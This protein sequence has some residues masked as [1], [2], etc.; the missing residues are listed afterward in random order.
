MTTQQS[1]SVSLF[2]RIYETEDSVTTLGPRPYRKV[3]DKRR[4]LKYSDWFNLSWKYVQ[5]D[6]VDISF[7]QV[8]SVNLSCAKVHDSRAHGCKFIKVDFSFACLQRTDLSHA[9]FIDCYLRGVLLDSASLDYAT[10]RGANLRDSNLVAASALEADFTESNF[11]NSNISHAFLGKSNFEGSIFIGAK[12]VGSSFFSCNLKYVNFAHSNLR[13]ATLRRAQLHYA[14]F[15]YADLSSA[16]LRGAN[17]KHTNFIGAI[18]KDT[19]LGMGVGLSF[20]QKK[21]LL[22]R[23]AVFEDPLFSPCEENKEIR[24]KK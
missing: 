9:K 21:Q 24:L 7:S 5:L 8:R 18:V 13:H 12:L 2:N 19:N 15:S 17:L 3:V 1:N 16:D 22:K 20:L 14:S 11:K 4:N 23:G 6:R 10:L